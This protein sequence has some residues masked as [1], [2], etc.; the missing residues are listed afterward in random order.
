MVISVDYPPRASDDAM[1]GAYEQQTVSSLATSYGINLMKPISV[2]LAYDHRNFYS[3]SKVP[4][5]C[6]RSTTFA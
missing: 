5:S 4:S 3:S 2:H 1:K 6:F